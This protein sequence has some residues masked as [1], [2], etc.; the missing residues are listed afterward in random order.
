MKLSWTPGVFALRFLVIF[1]V[2]AGGFEAARGTAFERLA[3]EGLILKPTASFINIVAGSE[4]TLLQGRTLI[5]GTAQLHVT[6]G[7][8]GIEMFLLLAAAILAYPAS[9]GRRAR[10]MLLGFGLAFILSVLRLTALDFTLRY[11]P[12]AWEA[13]HGL[14]LPLAAVLVMALYFALWTSSIRDA[15]P[16]PPQVRLHAP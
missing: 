4:P 10:G 1:A 11:A 15:A 6:R 2:L 7:C 3:V 12:G 8:E 9:G 13:L 5:S 14:V 16:L